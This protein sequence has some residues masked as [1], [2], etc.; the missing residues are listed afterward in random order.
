ISGLRAVV[1][2][3]QAQHFLLFWGPLYLL[4]LTFLVSQAPRPS[5][6]LGAGAAA[7]GLLVAA[8]AAFRYGPVVRLTGPVVPWTAALALRRLRCRSADS[9]P[10]SL[11]V[12]SLLF[13]GWLLVLGCDLLYVH[14]M[15]GGRQ[16]TV[17]KLYFQAWLLLGLAGSYMA[18]FLL[19]LVPRP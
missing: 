12:L 7:A 2:P 18:A 16:N 19:G 11:F 6:R 10:E 9:S 17:F 4:S 3:T 15:F 14:D 5:G 1:V 8:G 13:T